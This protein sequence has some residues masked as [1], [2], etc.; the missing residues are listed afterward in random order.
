MA[1]FSASVA[2]VDGSS[3]IARRDI[4]FGEVCRVLVSVNEAAISAKNELR[5]AFVQELALRSKV[6]AASRVPL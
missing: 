2:D 4:A 5:A 3:C 1:L 6:S